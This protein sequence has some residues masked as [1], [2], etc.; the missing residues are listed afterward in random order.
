MRSRLGL[1]GFAV[2]ATLL[3]AGCVGIP[4]SG[5]VQ[6]GPVIDDQLNPDFV[7][8]PSDPRAGSSPEEILAD[9]MQAVRGPQ[10]DYSVARKFLTKDLAENWDPDARVD[11]R[12]APAQT[13]PGLGANSLQYTVTSRA[14]VDADGRYIEQGP[15]TQTLQ[16]SFAKENGEWR[17]SK[18]ADGIVLSQSSFNVVF[19]ERAL[20][21]F[22]P[23]HTYL[24]PDVRWFP[25][26]ATVPVRTVRALLAGPASWLGQG[27]LVSAFPVATTLNSGANSVQVLAGMTTV[28][29]SKEALAASPAERDLMRQQL[30][31]TLGVPTVQMTVGGVELNSADG[32][33]AIA[34]PTPI[35]S[36]MLIGTGTA[37][38]FDSGDGVTAISALS[39]RLLAAGAVTLSLSNDKQSA[40]FLGADGSA[41]FARSGSEDP[42]VVD[43]R[44]GLAAPTLDPFLY[45][46]SAQAGSAATLT[47]FGADGTEHPVQSGL[48]AD[49]R[50][51]SMDMSRDGTRMLFYLSTDVGPR[52]IVAGVIRGQDN[53]P[54]ALGE[55]LA[56]PVSNSGPIDATWVDDRTVAV[57][58]Q[59]A[60]VASVTAF[61]LG[62]PSEALG[63]IADALSI[64]GG[65]GGSTASDGLRV[66]RSNG[67]AYRPAGSGGWVSTGI[68]ATFLGT[69][70]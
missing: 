5:G 13:I 38:G 4:T 46:W 70:Q 39:P 61:E 32:P 1:A 68:K 42:L 29:L 51:V 14:Y 27:V 69:K 7:V 11:I 50:I 64:V 40:A 25:S 59:D 44:G 49:A 23:S 36:A 24:V 8:L 17:I 58:S 54:S 62:G 31:A 15:A 43:S 41:Y 37:I 63:S 35:D 57:V 20:Y 10:N 45:V 52:L 21:F 18:A 66:L 55:P 65:N 12:T 33:S 19:T 47:T 9:F 34:N 60:G 56:L 6:T 48:P 16:F 53:V 26:R 3:L 28:D 22:D 2:A 67:E 30:A